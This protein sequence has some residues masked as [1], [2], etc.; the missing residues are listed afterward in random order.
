MEYFWQK[1]AFAEGPCLGQRWVSPA[2]SAESLCGRAGGRGGPGWA[3]KTRLRAE[4]V[5][6]STGR[7][8]FSLA[9]PSDRMAAQLLKSGR[10]AARGLCSVQPHPARSPAGIQGAGFQWAPFWDPNS[11]GML[12]GAVQGAE[13]RATLL[14]DAVEVGLV[15]EVTLGVAEVLGTEPGRGPGWLEETLGLE[16]SWALAARSGGHIPPLPFA[17]PASASPAKVHLPGL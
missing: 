17:L 13:K 10:K 8:A 4:Q 14:H 2:G 11:L 9:A 15:K 12:D 6:G 3:Q 7:P 5:D 16:W 1:K